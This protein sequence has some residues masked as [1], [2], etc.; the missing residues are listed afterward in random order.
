MAPQRARLCEDQRARSH[1]PR[2][3]LELPVPSGRDDEMGAGR[4][5][6]RW[7]EGE[8]ARERRVFQPF[9]E[10]TRQACRAPRGKGPRTQSPVASRPE[11]QQ[12]KRMIGEEGVS[13]KAW[14]RDTTAGRSGCVAPVV[15]TALRGKNIRACET[16]VKYL[17]SSKL[18]SQSSP[19]S[20]PKPV[21][22]SERRTSAVGE[23]RSGCPLQKDPPPREAVYSRWA[24]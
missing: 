18:A 6:V 11:R 7:R 17:K 23:A 21:T 4:R 19:W 2:L 16:S 13:C 1:V 20:Y 5:G 24:L 9:S 12:E 15:H 14:R 8:R 10:R 3:Q 22:S